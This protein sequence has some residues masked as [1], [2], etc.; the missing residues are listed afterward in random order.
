M[1]L[2]NAFAKL[3]TKPSTAF[4][5][6][7]TS[8]SLL[9]IATVGPVSVVAH[10]AGGTQASGWHL[11]Y[12]TPSAYGTLSQA[13]ASSVAGGLAAFNFTDQP[14]TALLTTN[15]KAQN[16]S[17]LGNL[18]GK[19]VTMNF[20]VSGADSAFTYYGEGTPSNP[21]GTPAS[22]RL[23]F[24]TS[25]AGGFDYSHYWWSNP[26]SSVLSNGDGTVTATLE[27][28]EWS[29]WGGQVGS[30]VPDQFNAAASNVTEMG[31]SFGGGCF[32]ENGVGTTDGL[33]TFTLNSYD[34]E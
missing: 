11:G 5:L 21:C 13:Q 26:A 4:H 33:G 24:E 10:A 12:Y 16:P 31:L 29:N 27:P 7:A 28:G 18:T 19:T 15:Q 22:V 17:L 8:I 34:V 2:H 32:F 9:V 23:Y 20:N 14:D 25:N 6:V 30:S 3:K 1:K